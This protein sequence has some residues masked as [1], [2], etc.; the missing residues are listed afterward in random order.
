MVPD[1]VNCPSVTRDPKDDYLVALALGS[2]VELLCTGDKDFDGVTDV[3]ITTPGELI[4]RMLG[5]G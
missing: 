4:A 5:G 2:G 3:Q 1:P